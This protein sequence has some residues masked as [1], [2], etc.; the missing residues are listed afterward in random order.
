M[1][2]WILKKG[3]RVH[4][5]GR[6]L[7]QDGTVIG[8]AEDDPTVPRIRLDSGMEWDARWFGSVRFIGPESPIF[9]PCQRNQ[10]GNCAKVNVFD[11]S[12]VCACGCHGE[13][14]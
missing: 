14:T 6:N 10:H 11:P 12:S 5:R 8:F 7:S 3:D 2:E 4:V 13:R 9:K 1:D